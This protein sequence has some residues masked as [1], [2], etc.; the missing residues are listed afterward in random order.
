MVR[1]V[2]E[3]ASA[4]NRIQNTLNLLLGHL[5]P[6]I[7]DQAPP[8]IR[9]AGAGEAVDLAS[10][11]VVAD[12][13]GQG[14]TLSL[15]SLAKALGVSPGDL[16][17]IAK[18]LKLNNRPNFSVVVRSGSGPRNSITNYH[19]RAIDEFRRVIIETQISSLSGNERSALRRL[20]SQLDG[21]LAPSS[22]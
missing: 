16:G 22:R 12:P 4:L 18:A 19:A 11:V 6:T 8:A 2:Q 17:V 9:I 21:K 13:I 3:Q 5:A 20:K 10:A 1:A 14:F 15:T 7:A